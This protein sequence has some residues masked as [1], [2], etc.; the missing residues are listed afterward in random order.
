M[1]AINQFLGFIVHLPLDAII[2]RR[3]E[4]RTPEI[5]PKLVVQSCHDV[6]PHRHIAKQPNI[7]KRPRDAV[8]GNAGGSLAA[9]L[10]EAP[11]MTNRDRAAGSW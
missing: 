8:L 3:M 10:V 6:F 2:A 9:D 4:N 11:I 1:I 7:L 5:F